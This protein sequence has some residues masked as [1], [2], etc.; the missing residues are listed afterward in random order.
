MWPTLELAP[1]GGQAMHDLFYRL[2]SAAGVK[3]GS[4]ADL[5]AIP[6]ILDWLQG[7]PLALALVVPLAMKNAGCSA[8]GLI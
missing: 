2:A 8:S 1:L 7:H 3:T 6:L 4:Q 5:D